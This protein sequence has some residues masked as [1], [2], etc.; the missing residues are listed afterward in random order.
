MR[1]YSTVFRF[2]VAVKEMTS[3]LGK[4]TVIYRYDQLRKYI[5]SLDEARFDCFFVDEV[6]CDKI[7]IQFRDPVQLMTFLGSQEWLFFLGYTL[8]RDH[9]RRRDNKRDRG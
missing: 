9:L 2:Y 4:D 7:E 5:S 1:E 3:L 8:D 6:A